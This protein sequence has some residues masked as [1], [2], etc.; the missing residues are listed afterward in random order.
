VQQ[1]KFV[2]EVRIFN[3][4]FSRDS[5]TIITPIV[6]ISIVTDENSDLA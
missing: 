4:D 2:M 3:N 5:I 1:K 6:T